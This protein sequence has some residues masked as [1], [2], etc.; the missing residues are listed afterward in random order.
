MMTTQE[1]GQLSTRVREKLVALARR[2]TQTAGIGDEPEDIVQEA[3]MALWELS[4]KGYPIQNAEA[5][6]VRLVKNGCVN[7]YRKRRLFFK[8]LENAAQAGSLPATGRLEDEENEMIR[9]HLYGKLSETQRTFLIMR[10][11]FGLSLDEIA[12]AT[13]RPKNS[14]KSSLSS[15]R[16]QLLE[17]LKKI[18]R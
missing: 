15:A 6:A 14:I 9:K 17:E 18:P 12:A 16:R 5:L 4:G 8:P 13:G 3:L 1:F 2:F 11:E 7:H 10:G